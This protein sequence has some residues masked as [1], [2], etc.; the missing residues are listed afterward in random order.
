MTYLVRVRGH[1]D[2]VWARAFGAAQLVREANGSTTLT[3]DVADQA[4]L[5]S[6]LMRVRDLGAPLLSVVRTDGDVGEPDGAPG[7]AGPPGDEDRR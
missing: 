5:Y 6:V 7:Q 1:L 2:D 4:A 3:V